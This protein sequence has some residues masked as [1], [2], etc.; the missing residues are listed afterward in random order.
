MRNQ[1]PR[2]SG[3]ARLPLSQKWGDYRKAVAFV[4]FLGALILKQNS[5]VG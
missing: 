2:C 4:R 5:A 1:F 3:I